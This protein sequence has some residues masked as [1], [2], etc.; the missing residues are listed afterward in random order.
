VQAH[1]E[2][3]TLLYIDKSVVSEKN[4]HLVVLY[5]LPVIT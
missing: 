5:L 2:W 1:S 3:I 4:T